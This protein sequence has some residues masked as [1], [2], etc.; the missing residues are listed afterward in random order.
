[1][2]DIS[3]A[4]SWNVTWGDGGHS[5]MH[6][7][8][9]EVGDAGRYISM[10]FPGS[11]TA[12]LVKAGVV[13]D[14]RVGMNA[15]HARWVEEHFWIL[16]KTFH[17]PP[18]AAAE[19]PFLYIDVLDGP[20][21]I[22]LNG[23]VIGEHA[24]SFR[25][26]VFDL[27]GKLK[28][29]KNELVILI[30]SG[31]FRVADLPGNDYSMQEESMLVKRHHLRQPQYQFGWDWNPRLIYFGLHGGMKIVWGPQPRLEQVKVLAQ[32]ADDLKNATVSIQSRWFVPGERSVSM[33]MTLK[34]R[35]GLGSNGTVELQPGR[36]DAELVVH[37][38][39]PKL[40]YPRGHG[41][42]ELYPLDVIFMG[43]NQYVTRWMGQT[44]LRKVEIEQPAH[45]E[46]GRFFH[47]KVNNRI[48]F[49][50][51]SNWVP[52]EMSAFEVDAERV[53]TLVD[54]AVEQNFNMLRL[55]GGAVW[56]GHDL[57]KLCDEKGIMVWHDLLFACSKF[58]ADDPDWL[59]GVESEVVWGLR[60]F[61]THPSLVVWCGNNELEVGLWNWHYKDFGRTAPDYALFH[62]VIPTLMA[63]NDPSR[64]YWPSSPYSDATHPADDPTRGDQHPWFVSLDSSPDA[65][66][67]WRY[68]EQV[69][70][71]PNEGGVL[72]CSPTES[73]RKFLSRAELKPRSFAWEVHDNTA[74]FWHAR[75]GTTYLHIE[76]FLNRKVED[77]SLAEYAI[78]SG[79]M[80]AEGLKEYIRNY[81]RRFP[82]TSAAIYWD[83]VDSWPSVHGWGTL[84]YYLRRKPS[85]HVV[86]RA[87]SP[88]ICVL[89][90]EGRSIGVYVIN[91]SPTEIQV[92]VEAGDFDTTSAL[93]LQTQRML[94]AKPYN[95][96]K[97][98]TLTRDPLRIPY[99]VVRGAGFRLLD[100]DRLLLRPFHEWQ[101]TPPNIHVSTSDVAGRRV[102]RYQSQQWVWNVV[103]DPGGSG[104]TRDDHFD[105]LPN[106]PY[107][108]PLEPGEQARPVRYTGNQLLLK[109][110]Q[111]KTS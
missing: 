57:L 98:S 2:A 7:H 95:V 87:F 72:G 71:F 43:D 13:E 6:H 107:D 10:E 58:P 102:A 60:E 82:S 25:P 89:A 110:S 74:N 4:G 84:D 69:D 62:Q 55:W 49:C 75:S 88:I 93:R 32:V 65:A 31:L 39:D 90:D 80:Q 14:P 81:R 26:A 38:T 92:T 103:L 64:P 3:L 46:V 42:Q 67:F 12:N 91:D 8:V 100:Y 33:A 21:E 76:R 18:E 35:D 20:A 41:S 9:Q 29:L 63:D 36:L 68:R 79:V 105:L 108:V 44:G 66:D 51:G 34:S 23:E 106:Q 94:S 85:Y 24:N 30:E 22:I 59:K 47:L 61:C 73:L 27:S 104:V 97:V 15:L 28:P 53:K 11:I 52:P 37:I 83:Y 54:L 1:M 86:R 50:K 70:R 17:V 111:V 19:T 101:V 99:A 48:I 45:P 56:A 16:R 77:L 40:W 5:K 96:E 109:G 78:A